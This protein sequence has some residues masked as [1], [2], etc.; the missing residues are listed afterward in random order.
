MIDVNSHEIEQKIIGCFDAELRKPFFESTFKIILPD[1]RGVQYNFE[2]DAREFDIWI[3]GPKRLSIGLFIDETY[4]IEIETRKCSLG[5]VNHKHYD[6]ILFSVILVNGESNRAHY[7]KKAY[8]LI[9]FKE[10]YFAGFNFKGEL[11][12]LKGRKID[13]NVK[14]QEYAFIPKVVN[15]NCEMLKRKLGE[16]NVEPLEKILGLF[17]SPNL[18]KGLLYFLCDKLS[19]GYAKKVGFVPDLMQSPI[20]SNGLIN[21]CLIDCTINRQRI[22]ENKL[23]KSTEEYLTL[24]Y[25]K[26]IAKALSSKSFSLITEDEVFAESCVSSELLEIYLLN[27]DVSGKGLKDYIKKIKML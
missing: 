19:E 7:T 11:P 6:N 4:N 23:S 5:V 26:K 20:I 15:N 3:N 25:G 13:T 2:N 14:K 21:H 1:S 17:I 27:P 22:L 8:S 18:K 10:D 12:S 9:D 16:C 24:N